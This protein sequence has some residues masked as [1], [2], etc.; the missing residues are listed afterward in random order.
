[1]KIYHYTNL[2]S[3][4]MI[5]KNKTI[6]FNRLD[7]V[8]DLEEGNTESLGI[9][10]C[11][12]IL[13]QKSDSGKNK[14]EQQV[15]DVGIKDIVGRGRTWNQ[16]CLA[17]KISDT[18]HQSHFTDIDRIASQV[19]R[20]LFENAHARQLKAGLFLHRMILKKTI[21]ALDS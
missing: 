2:E 15:S 1:M 14:S 9:C 11:K 13:F 17:H 7:K 3:L 4:A 18:C 5:L 16:C 10:F 21:A 8:D 20:R 19:F 6:R 12:Y